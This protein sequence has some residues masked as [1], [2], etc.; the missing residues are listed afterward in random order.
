MIQV[1]VRLFATLRQSAGWK[2]K[3]LDVPEATTVGELLKLLEQSYPTLHLTGRSLYAA[4]NQ[5]YAQFTQPVQ[6]GDEVALF[7]PVS[8]GALK[9]RRSS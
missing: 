1:K 6:P 3:L 4:V 8:G 9:R 2:E 7:P 5:E